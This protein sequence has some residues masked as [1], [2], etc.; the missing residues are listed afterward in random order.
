[1]GGSGSGC[2]YHWWRSGKKTVVADCKSL[3]SNRWMRE[4]ILKAGVWHSGRWIWFIDETRTEEASSIGYEV[5]TMGELP[6]M[7]LTYTI[8]RTKDAL[9]Y[10]IRLV[11]TCPRFGGLRWWFICPLVRDGRACGRRV[12]KLYLPPGGRCYGCRHCYDL[13]YTSCQESRK[14]DSMFRWLARDTGY[15][16]ATVKHQVAP[17]WWNRFDVRKYP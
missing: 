3:D 15:D 17:L 10:R 13:T 9:D 6:W 14:Y 5:N 12:G 8:T 1:M 7:R 2:S 16:F 4:G 11:T